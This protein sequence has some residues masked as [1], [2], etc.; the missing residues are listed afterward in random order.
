MDE[1]NNIIVTGA[2]LVQ[3]DDFV[4]L[5]RPV[6]RP[7]SM[8]PEELQNFESF[9][10]EKTLA[11]DQEKQKILENLLEQRRSQITGVL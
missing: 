6:R 2:N 10:Q 5:L 4:V 9:I 8:T 1:I 7:P 11:F 3:E